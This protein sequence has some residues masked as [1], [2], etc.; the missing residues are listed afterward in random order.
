MRLVCPNCDAQYEIDS[1][2]I[3]AKGREVQCSNCAH[4]WVQMPEPV[5]ET[6]AEPVPGMVPRR[7]KTDPN[8][9]NII[10]EEV[11]RETRARVADGE[12]FE[13]Q[14][15]LDLSNRRNARAGS[16]RER[17][18]LDLRSDPG[19]AVAPTRDDQAKGELFPDIEELNSTLSEA[20]APEDVKEAFVEDRETEGRSGFRLGFGLMV[21]LAVLALL[22]YIY[23]P[24][25]SVRLPALAGILAEY[26]IFVDGLRIWLDDAAHA[27]LGRVT[28]M[29][30]SFGRS[31]P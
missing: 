4:T 6:P 31:E 27:L 28:E 15:E 22:L 18:G 8:A 10:H 5:G 29:T 14:G 3:P 19:I 17:T 25:I 30:E 7:P 12:A 20:P 9:L 24:D 1:N 23:A 16:L 21:L 13:T 11:E 26:V 2:A